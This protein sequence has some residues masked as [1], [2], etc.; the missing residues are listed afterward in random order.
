MIDHYKTC[1]HLPTYNDRTKIIP[2]TLNV[3]DVRLKPRGLND[4][5][6]ILK[7]LEYAV[8]IIPHLEVY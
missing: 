5:L 3:K 2:P 6:H 7:A 1:T 8:L 4:V